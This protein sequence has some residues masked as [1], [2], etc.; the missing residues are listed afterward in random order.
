[1]QTVTALREAIDEM[2]EFL[3]PIAEFGTDSKTKGRPISRLWK[4]VVSL[5]MERE[6]P[7]KLGR[8]GRLHT[9]L[10]R[11]LSVVGIELQLTKE[12]ATIVDGNVSTERFASLEAQLTALSAD[13]K[14]LGLTITQ[15]Q[16][17]STPE[18]SSTSLE[19]SSYTSSVEAMLL[20]SEASSDTSSDTDSQLILTPPSAS[21]R[22]ESPLSRNSP[23]S[24]RR[25]EQM[26]AHI[27]RRMFPSP[28]PVLHD[29]G[30]CAHLELVLFN[31]RTYYT[32]GN[33]QPEPTVMEPRF[34][35][36]CSD[37]IYFFKI[38]D[39]PKAQR[40]LQ[41][42]L[43]IDPDDIF[44]EGSA[45]A[46]IEIL[47]TLSPINTAV[48]P[49]VRKTLL[50]YLYNLA[51]KHLPRYNPIVV[52]VS[53][54]YEGMDSADW[55]VRA[56][57]F[58][59]DRLRANL[60][61]ANQLRLLAEERLITLLHRGHYYDEAL[62]V[63]ND[64][65]Q[66][67]RTALGPDSPQERQLARRLEHIYM[68]QC[69]WD[70]ALDVCFKIVGQRLFNNTKEPMPDPQI[71]DECAVWT[72]EDIA[73]I[74]DCVGNFTSAIA[75]LKQA[76][77]SGGICWG[78]GVRLEHIHDKLLELLNRHELDQE[79]QLWSTAFGPVHIIE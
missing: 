2:N 57:T 18:S 67:I 41:K 50:V 45:V 72:M 42:S 69:E 15:P 31:I 39:L 3:S 60:D 74:Y 63:C 47:S 36:E 20:A 33:F 19:K 55:S 64:T 54:L 5:K 44:V 35:T 53:R 79:A 75:W 12:K 71:H 4:S 58:I 26:R 34:W 68:G 17:L 62:Q 48:N 56:L 24:Q 70:S 1:M 76:R 16:P 7:D 43:T 61:P 28:K 23:L 11:E 25:K 46:L 14:S 51:I 30:I 40:S 52:V 66:G 78:A 9:N 10:L 6:L 27:E 59:V 32:K 22:S 73:K 29:G 37:S 8:L 65:M 77:V 13:I 38:A 49:H 21:P